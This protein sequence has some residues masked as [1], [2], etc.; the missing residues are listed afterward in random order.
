MSNSEI[1]VLAD[2]PQLQNEL[3]TAALTWRRATRLRFAPIVWI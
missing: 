1:L 2:D 3:Q